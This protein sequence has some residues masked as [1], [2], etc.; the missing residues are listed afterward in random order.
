M[1]VLIADDHDLVRETIAMFLGKD[2]DI[3][4]ETASTLPEALDQ[5]AKSPFDIV[6]LDYNMPGMNGLDGLRKA[7]EANGAKTVAI[8][9]GSAP[10]GVAQEAITEGA[11]GFLPKTQGAQSL[12]N[13]IRFMASGE[14]YMP[15]SVM[16]EEEAASTN[17]LAQALSARE[18][19]V[20][21]G[22]CK[23]QSNKEIARVL[24]L[25]EVTIKLH[26]KT[27]CRKLDA[28]NRTQAAMMA[29]EANLF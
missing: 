16:R 9:S 12:V 8:L 10:R 13:A 20:L 22:L 1:R 26:V 5:I 2:A 29:K 14:T 4:T 21:Q 6:L 27:L 15:I 3:E 24:D 25:Q 19:Q 11:I 17:P 18:L 28:K 7:T 23:G